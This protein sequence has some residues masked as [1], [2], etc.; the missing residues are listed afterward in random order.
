MKGDGLEVEVTV[1]VNGGDDVLES[2][3]DALDGSS[4]DDD[5]D[6]GS[7]LPLECA[8]RAN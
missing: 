6:V 1:K 8:R 3:D 2:E 4:W 7:V 5:L